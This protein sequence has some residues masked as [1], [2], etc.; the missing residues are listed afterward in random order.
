MR[1][2]RPT[3]EP[4]SSHAAYLVALRWLSARE[5]TESQV[6]QRLQER[7]FSSEA[8]ALAIDRLLQQRA[9]DDRRTALSIAR[10]EAT[11][12]HRGPHR[13]LRR[14]LATG[15]DREVARAV[16]REVFEDLNEHDLM[17]RA[18]AKRLRPG[19]GQVGDGAERRRLQAY[20]VRQGFASSAVAA[21]LRE[22]TRRADTT[23][24][25]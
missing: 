15:I 5:L 2:V 19:S 24:D 12:R 16:V 10:T 25:D 6:R 21:L 1:R 4:D 22:R 3:A 8:V 17:R 11:I 9:L 20:L 13:V 18:L 14:L 7:N 23:D